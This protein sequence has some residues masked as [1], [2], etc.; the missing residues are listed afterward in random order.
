MVDLAARQDVKLTRVQYD[1]SYRLTAASADIISEYSRQRSSLRRSEGPYL[2]TYI[3]R[4]FADFGLTT[5]VLKA[6]L[7]AID[8][9]NATS[10]NEKADASALYFMVE[11][12]CAVGPANFGGA[13][14]PSEWS[15]LLAIAAP[16]LQSDILINEEKTSLRN[17]M[18]KT[19]A[20]QIC[21]LFLSKPEV[22][23]VRSADLPSYIA[24]EDFRFILNL[25][26]YISGDSGLQRKRTLR[27]VY[28]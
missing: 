7:F 13:S 27:Y 4:F 1:N 6:I 12:I 10:R 3:A 17:Y 22:T 18:Q 9:A 25:W 11:L 5:R 24:L 8:L 19:A 16:A 2:S 15:Q 14:V 20:L 28:G 21:A 23:S 26:A